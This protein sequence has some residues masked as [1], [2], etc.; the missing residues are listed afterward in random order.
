VYP[1]VDGFLQGL[2]EHGWIEGKTVAIEYRWAAG[3]VDALPELARELVGREVEV[4]VTYGNK[5]PHALKDIVKITPIVA[6][7]CD[8]LET[9]VGSLARP[10]GNITG[11]TCL[12]SELTPKKLELLLDITPTAKRLAM[13]YNPSDPGPALALKLAREV[14]ER[15]RLTFQPVTISA[16]RISIGSWRPSPM[17]VLM[18]C[19]SIPTR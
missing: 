1:Y 9:M 15:R 19:T 13:L 6:L 4:I 7:S 11:L 2:R 17:H 16:W 3:R 10:G 18:C 8:P 14:T 12:S 5:P